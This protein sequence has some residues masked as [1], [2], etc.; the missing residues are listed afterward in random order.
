MLLKDLCN[1]KCTFWYCC[2]LWGITPTFS[3]QLTNRS[4][5]CTAWKVSKYGVSLRIQS[6]AEKYEPEKIPYL[7]TS[8]SVELFKW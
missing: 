4:I 7:D 2:W 1:E 6:K 5:N 8:R 3:Q